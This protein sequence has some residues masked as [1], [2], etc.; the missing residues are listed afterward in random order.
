MDIVEVVKDIKDRAN[1]VL[2]WIING[3]VITPENKKK[4]KKSCRK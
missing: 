3:K 2:F 4:E 1:K